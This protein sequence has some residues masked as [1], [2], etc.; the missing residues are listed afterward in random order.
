MLTVGLTGGI[1]TGKS[2]VAN[3]L[4]DKGCYVENADLLAQILMLPGG[5]AYLA[6]IN[7]FGQQILSD[8]G[9]IDRQKLARIIFMEPEERDVLNSLTHP[10]ILRKVGQKV[11]S[12][13]KSG[14]YEIYVT[15]A[16]L[17]LEAGYQVFYDRV[18]LTFCKPE[19]QVERLIQ[20]DGLSPE[21]AWLKIKSQWPLEKKIPLADY[22]IDTSG[23]LTETVEQTE[24][25]YLRLYHDSQLKKMGKLIREVD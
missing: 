8:D 9:S 4:Q 23:Q 6:V 15:E 17:I 13:E 12:L 16:A 1:A 7:H 22:L 11:A 21:E 3:I 10:L 25:L 5:E 2:V 14:D 18:V 19:T 24:E 20:R